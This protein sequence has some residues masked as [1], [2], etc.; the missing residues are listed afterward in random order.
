MKSKLF[1]IDKLIQAN[2]NNAGIS[3]P[4]VSHRPPATP[5]PIIN[6]LGQLQD[7]VNRHPLFWSRWPYEPQP[8]CYSDHTVRRANTKMKLHTG[9]LATYPYS[10]SLPSVGLGYQGYLTRGPYS[11]VLSSTYSTG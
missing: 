6:S 11:S 2:S 8:H 5:A 10:P 7:L 3:D 9:S 1:R 4:I